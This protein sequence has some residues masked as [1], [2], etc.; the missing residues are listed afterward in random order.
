MFDISNN[1]IITLTR[2]DSFKMPLVLNL[3]TNIRPRKVSLDENSFVYFAVMEPNQ[4]FEDALIRKKYDVS[5]VDENGDVI[6]SFKPQD[7]QCVLP[8]KYY[9]QVKLQVINSESPEDYDVYTVVD[10]TLF[11]IL[12]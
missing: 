7:T 10:K 1:G 4:P 3:G 6:V 2:G 9:Y 12:E 8:G 11:W 5:D